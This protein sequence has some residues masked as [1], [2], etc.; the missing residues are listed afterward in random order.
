[1]R[2]SGP[3]PDPGNRSAAGVDLVTPARWWRP[4]RIAVVVGIF[5]FLAIQVVPYGWW[6]QNPPVQA[7]AVW[8][9]ATA[10]AAARAACYD[11]HSHETRWPLY[12]YV[13]PMSWL[14]RRDVEEGRDE[15]NFS[16]WD[17]GDADDAVE[18]ILDGE[19]PPGRY[20][21]IHRD[22][23]LSDEQIDALIAALR[24]ME[25]DD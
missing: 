20:T 4:L 10:E 2:G 19:M 3:G 21:M 24:Q 23:S 13:A 5:V 22:A 25:Q 12:S 1:M 15:L 11:C 16:D 9:E 14:V 7:A 18:T 6:H 17:P 8:P